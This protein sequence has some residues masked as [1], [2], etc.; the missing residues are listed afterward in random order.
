MLVFHSFSIVLMHKFFLLYSN[1]AL[2][3]GSPALLLLDLRILSGKRML[4]L[5]FGG[6]VILHLYVDVLLTA[7][8]LL[9]FFV[10]SE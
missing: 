2:F 5:L 9:Q 8:D 4:E 3:L 6:L 7:N 10:L 1:P